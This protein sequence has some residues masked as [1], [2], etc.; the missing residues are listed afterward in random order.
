V[1]PIVDAGRGNVAF[2][3]FGHRQAGAAAHWRTPFSCWIRGDECRK[4]SEDEGESHCE[5]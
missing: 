5:D 1:A 3:L 4:D 2:V